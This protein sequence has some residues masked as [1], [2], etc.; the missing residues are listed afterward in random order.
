MGETVTYPQFTKN[1]RIGNQFFQAAATIAYGL[2]NGKDFIFPVEW[3]YNK[4]ML[5]PLPYGIIFPT[6]H[7]I[8]P[9]F[10]YAPIPKLDG[11]VALDGFFQSPLY[12]QHRKTDILPYFTLA[13]KYHHYIL[14]KYAKWLNGNTCSIHVR[15]GDYFN[16]GTN[17]Y[18]GVLPISY[19][20]DAVREIYG[21]DDRDDLLF[22][23][24]SDGISWCRDNFKFKNMLFIEGEE[25]VIDLFIMSYCMNHIIANSAFSWWSAWLGKNP[26]RKVV[27]PK[28]W[29]ANAPHDPKD[30][31]CKDWIVI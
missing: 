20:E 12:F 25:D 13:D 14:L 1:G 4:Y 19:Y 21:C 24:C 28:K 3:E 2:D 23:I 11:S 22:V 30:I 7:Y 18:H 16:R 26:E 15:H 8:E 10:H 27:A 9:N 5:K 29:F 6:M 31:Y 17:E